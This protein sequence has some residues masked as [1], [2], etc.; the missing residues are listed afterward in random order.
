MEKRKTLMPGYLKLWMSRNRMYFNGK[1]CK[2]LLLLC[3][4]CNMQAAVY[5]QSRKEIKKLGIKSETVKVVEVANG[6]EKEIIES[7]ELYDDNGNTVS[8]KEYDKKGVVQRKE[9]RTYNKN[10]DLTE[11]VDYG[12]NETV[13]KKTVVLYNGNG[14]KTEEK[15]TDQSGK[16][17]EWYKHG[18]NARGEKIYELKLAPDAKT[19]T[20][21]IFTY[22]NKGLKSEKKV[23]DANDKLLIHKRY[24]Y[25]F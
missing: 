7:E 19:I 13:I 4:F 3:I 5:A 17:T 20:K 16:V 12:E 2:P 21:S 24:Y 14:E 15:T 8:E 25:R 9:V 6:Q 22:N 11:E 23:F 10:G 1:F 18:Y